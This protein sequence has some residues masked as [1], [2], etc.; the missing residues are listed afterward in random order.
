MKGLKKQNA[1]NLENLGFLFSRKIID[2][3]T[4]N[5]YYIILNYWKILKKLRQF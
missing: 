1:E 5:K 2:I 4:K 3:F